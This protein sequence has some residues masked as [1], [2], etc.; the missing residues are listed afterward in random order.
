[1][2]DA[3]HSSTST[4]KIPTVQHVD[5]IEPLATSDK[6]QQFEEES[7]EEEEDRQCETKEDSGNSTEFLQNNE[8][9]EEEEDHVSNEKLQKKG[10]AKVDAPTNQAI[11]NIIAVVQKLVAASQ[12]ES[13][14]DKAT[15]LK[16]TE[17]AG[18]NNQ[19]IQHPNLQPLMLLR[20]FQH[21][22]VR[23]GRAR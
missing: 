2:S 8:E 12:P 22:L 3:R 16:K 14:F 21:R 10:I 11:L 20:M 13:A 6:P 15:S 7:E 17:I 1:M 4:E 19:M 23:S 18:K 5:V 9:Y